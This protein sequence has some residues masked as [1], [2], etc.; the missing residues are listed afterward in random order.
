MNKLA[1]IFFLF[2]FG[3]TTSTCKKVNKYPINLNGYWVCNIGFCSHYYIEIRKD[4]TATYAP[5]SGDVGCGGKK[6]TGKMRYNKDH[7]YLGTN[8][9]TFLEKPELFQGQDSIQWYFEL[10]TVSKTKNCYYKIL[11]TMKLK[12]GPL[13]HRD[14][15]KF[16][17][18]VDY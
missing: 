6:W 13:H 11:A 14:E 10:P 12:L 18:I 8:K 17:K 7:L 1:N 9:F 4:G 3:F 2:L 15:Y 5:Y 16:Y